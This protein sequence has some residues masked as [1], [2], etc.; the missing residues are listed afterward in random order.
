M[1]TPNR[2]IRHL[3]L[4]LGL[5]TSHKHALNYVFIPVF[6]GFFTPL[7]NGSFRSLTLSFI[8]PTTSGRDIKDTLAVEEIL[9][10]QDI[11]GVWR[12]D[13]DNAG[14]SRH[15]RQPTL[16]KSENTL[17]P[18]LKNLWELLDEHF[19]KDYN[20]REGPTFRGISI[21]VKALRRA[22]IEVAADWS[23]SFT[24]GQHLDS[25]KERC[26][27]DDCGMGEV[28][29]D[30]LSKALFPKCQMLGFEVKGVLGLDTKV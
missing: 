29:F 16:R 11:N 5:E 15:H 3:K 17:L 8:S 1:D 21:E 7:D 18:M 30:R 13:D 14:G 28:E 24:T 27:S 22:P 23:P 6:L 25:P 20:R 4:S 2:T 26:Q 10:R 9:G 19:C 12:K